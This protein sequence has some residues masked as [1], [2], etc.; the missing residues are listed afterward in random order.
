MV[1]I[2]ISIS[3]RMVADFEL[4]VE[5]GVEMRVKRRVLFIN[6]QLTGIIYII[7]SDQYFTLHQFS[8][9]NMQNTEYFIK[10]NFY[11]IPVVYY[12]TIIC[13]TLT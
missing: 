12:K 1:V 6:V 9:I 2:A 10:V 7:Q 11:E 5:K 13:C 4:K 8:R 3:P